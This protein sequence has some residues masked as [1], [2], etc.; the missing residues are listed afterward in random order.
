M[1]EEH[2]WKT[3][4]PLRNTFEEDAPLDGCMF[5]TYG[6]EDEFV[7]KQQSNLI[8]T[9]QDDDNGDPVIC[10]GWHYVNRIGY[11]VATVPYAGEPV[12][13]DLLTED[14]KKELRE[15]EEAEN[16]R[17]EAEHGR[18]SQEANG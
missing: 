1:T 6:R 16:R 3:Y 10:S 17:W 15:D 18:H 12:C 8:W 5:E 7:R 14:E 4:K 13:I 2:F 11:L 9:Y